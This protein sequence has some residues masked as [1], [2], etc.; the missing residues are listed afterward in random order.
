MIDKTI[1]TLPRWKPRAFFEQPDPC[2]GCEQLA[3]DQSRVIEALGIYQSSFPESFHQPCRFEQDLPELCRTH[4]Y[5]QCP[6][7]MIKTALAEA[8]RIMEGK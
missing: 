2:E 7:E 3:A 1:E 8:Q 4:N 6:V 5:E